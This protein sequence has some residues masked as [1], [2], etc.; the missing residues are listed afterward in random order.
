MLFFFLGQGLFP[1]KV[2]CSWF[3][4]YIFQC[5]VKVYFLNVGL[6]NPD[7]HDRGTVLGMVVCSMEEGLG[8][9][10]FSQ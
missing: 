2:I 5:D 1:S 10:I 4:F 9:D 3:G 7:P 6:K 8:E